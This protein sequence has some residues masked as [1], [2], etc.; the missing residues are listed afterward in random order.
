MISIFK[1]TAEQ[2][3]EIRLKDITLEP[4]GQVNEGLSLGDLLGN[5]FTLIIRDT[6]PDDLE[7]RYVRPMRR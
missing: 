5:R 1:V 3:S 4:V 6:L 2:V 7:A